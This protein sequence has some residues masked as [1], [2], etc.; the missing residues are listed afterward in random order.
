MKKLVC[1]LSLVM[2]LSGANYASQNAKATTKKSTV[3][4]M[5]DC[6]TVND[7]KLTANVKEKFT[8][9][10]VLKDATLGVEAQNGIVT[11]TG[12]VPKGATKGLATRQAKRVPCVK[13][14]HN[15]ITVEGSPAKSSK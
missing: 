8:N 5:V 6:S 12:K 2:F 9:T 13:D 3:K 1:V 14:V 10:K 15:Q 11:L 7:P 4:E